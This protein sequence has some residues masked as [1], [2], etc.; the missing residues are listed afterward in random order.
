MLFLFAIVLFW[1][2]HS[3]ERCPWRMVTVCSGSFFILIPYS[4][5]IFE[6]Q[7]KPF[8]HPLCPPG[9][10][11]FVYGV[12]RALHKGI[13]AATWWCVRTASFCM[14]LSIIISSLVMHGCVHDHVAISLCGRLFCDTAFFFVNAETNYI[15]V[16]LKRAPSPSSLHCC[17]C[18]RRELSFKP[19]P[20]RLQALSTSTPVLR[21]DLFLLLW[22]PECGI[23]QASLTR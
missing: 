23:L 19:F 9:T 22:L 17:T 13:H 10:W 11:T 15:L 1:P 6:D 7:L 8:C 21:W 5:Y 4:V 18:F 3:V 2:A 12:A 20:A 14:C 16:I